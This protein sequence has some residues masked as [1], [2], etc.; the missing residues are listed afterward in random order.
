MLD[1]LRSAWRRLWNAPGFSAMAVLTLAL[2]IG[3]NTAI[4][5]I[6]DAVLFR[7][8]PYQDA[9]Q[10]HVMRMLDRKTSLRFTLVS[11][12]FLRAVNG[13]HA[14]GGGLSEVGLLDSAPSVLV[15]GPDGTESVTMLAATTNYFQVMGV[16]AARGRVFD[17][18]DESGVARTAVLSWTAWRQRFGG[19]EHVVGRAVTL[20]DKTFDIVGVLPPGLMFPTVFGTRPELVVVTAW[21]AVGEQGGAFLPVIRRDP[22]VTREI[23]QA[24]IDAAT[25]AI[26][27]ADPRMANVGPVLED[28]RAVLYPTGRPIMRWLLT[29]SALVWLIG[30]ANLANMLLARSQR[31]ERETALRAAL[32][33]SRLRLL[34]PI[35]F[36]SVIIGVAGAALAVVVTA[37]V[38]DALLRQVP[39]VAYGNAPVGVDAR[40]IAITIAMGLVGGLFFSV[41]PAWRSSRLDVQTLMQARHVRGGKRSGRF[42]R[43][44]VALQVAVA[45]VL[46]FGAVLTGRAFLSVLRVPLG[47]NADN[48]AT[49]AV[50]PRDLKGVA[51]QD[52][53]MRAVEIL[54]RRPDVVASGAAGS[55][56]FSGQAP[57]ESVKALASGLRPAGIVHALPGYIETI[58]VAITRGRSLTWDDVRGGGSAAVVSE[59]AARAIFADREPLGAVFENSRGRQFTVVG[60]A[61]NV[62]R[63]LPVNARDLAVAYVI[64]NDSIRSLTLVLRTRQRQDVLLADIKRDIAALAPGAPITVEWWSD[65]I[66]AVTAYRNPRFQTIVLGSLAALALGLTALGIFGVVAFLVATRTREMGVRLAI[67]ATPQSLVAMMVRQSL[68]PVVVGAILGV[69]ATRALSQFAES[70]LFEVK[71]HDPLTLAVAV[72]TV[73]LAALLAAYLPARQ[74]SRVDPIVVLRAE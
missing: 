20:G 33:A 21:P 69:F 12:D 30:C 3:A 62:Q 38:F 8:L 50:R 1:D 32:G 70:Q 28:M 22:G 36:E 4:F 56:P 61:S 41:V 35:V 48:V 54:S 17:A 40:V 64:P 10:L 67:G 6:A 47:F 53:Y 66:R 7:P 25:A 68:A 42:G 49:I 55:M 71:A 23:A 43:P 11:F 19:D 72:V 57:D 45:I 5:S 46:V 73:A 13:I 18:S 37:A 63:S 65:Q 52:A 31:R 34:R 26:S 59:A 24:R 74:A 29:A 27:A 60:V 44:M 51:L 39:R 14:Q 15:S 58:G 9:D 2:A 16:R